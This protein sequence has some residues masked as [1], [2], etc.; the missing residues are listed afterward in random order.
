MV[1]IAEIKHRQYGSALF[2][3]PGLN[4]R[5][6]YKTSTNNIE[7]ITAE[8]NN[9][10]ITSV[11]KPPNE[12][13][14]FDKTLN[15]DSQPTRFVVGDFNSH[16]ESWDYRAADENG[17]LVEEWADSYGI[18][19]IHDPKL[20]SSFNSGRWKRGYNPDL[21]FTSESVSKQCRKSVCEVIPKT[22]HRPIV[23]RTYEAVRPRI[24]PFR[25]RYNFAKANW[26][27]YSKE[28]DN[29]VSHLPPTAD[30]YE[31]FIGLVKLASRRHIPRGC[32]TQYIP[33]MSDSLKE[34][35]NA[36]Y[37][38]YAVDPFSQETILQ[39]NKFMDEISETQ[40]QKWNELVESVDMT[41]NS[42]KAWNFINK[43][44][45]DNKN[46]TYLA[47]IT[48]Y[49]IAHQLL[50]N[51]KTTDKCK[52]LKLAR[53]S[54]GKE[55]NHL[56]DLFSI[57][58]LDASIQKLKAGKAAGIDDIRVEQIKHFGRATK[59]WLLKL[60]NACVE[61]TSFP[62]I[63]RKSHVSAILKPGKDPAD[64]KSYRPISLLCH[65]FKLFERLILERM[66]RTLEDA[67]I[68][69]QAGFRAGK[70]CTSQVLNLTQYIEDGFEGGMVTGA[71]FVDLTAAYDTINHRRLVSKLYQITKDYKLTQVISELLSNRRF[72]V[73]FQGK[74]S[75]WRSLKNGLPQGSVLAPALFNIYTNDQPILDNLQHFLFADDLALTSQEKSFEAVENRL[76][77]GLASLSLYYKENQ[78]KPNPSKTQVCAFHLRNS[79]ATRQ[80]NIVWEDRRLEHTAALKYLGVTLD[81]SL[82]YKAH[83]L[84]T[85][86]KVAARN[87]ILRRITGTTWGATPHTLRTTALAL[88]F[89]AAEYACPVWKNSSHAAQVDIALNE[90]CR[91]VTGCLKPTKRDHLYQLSGI[92]PPDIRR[93]V[94]G[95][96]ERGKQLRDLRHPLHN[97]KPVTARLKSRKSF[98]TNSA[99][100]HQTPQE[101]RLKS[102]N[103][104]LNDTSLRIPA[105]ELLPP[106]GK[107]NWAVWKALNRLRTGVGR[108]KDNLLRWG[109]G[110][111]GDIFCECGVLQTTKHM[112]ECSLCSTMCTEEDLLRATP[113]GLEVAKHWK[114]R[115]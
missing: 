96:V 16:S 59:M 6:V 105:A 62:K 42:K 114:T 45:S 8:L 87:N 46:H 101:A 88:S 57:S 34:H 41:H 61:T 106:G 43:L 66:T 76:V 7:I 58:E 33:G 79:Q 20:P 53:Y 97:H 94:A 11:Y 37:N 75:R 47:N 4:I 50:L 83:C 78:L 51:G 111:Q 63:W 74:K 91:L 100:Q 38:A 86:Q 18:S 25:R 17:D 13:F 95:A 70:S 49:Q 72:Y 60:F 68:D 2:V 15:F 48:A 52:P 9:C 14:Q 55:R 36:Y 31:E 40:R 73:S 71:V 84:N 65:T 93:D 99:L 23:C 112:I 39:G 113:R 3:R 27:C 77:E 10:T 67:F 12:K 69:Q 108:S 102:W 19:L 98:V 107:E 32:K 104:Q 24:V 82:T 44:S 29:L 56:R 85:K 103:S 92:A 30:S 115:I 89:S 28:L 110:R 64:V 80:L 35:A 90:S 1:L 22:Q 109:I 54:P 5:S 81:R 26:E 21:I